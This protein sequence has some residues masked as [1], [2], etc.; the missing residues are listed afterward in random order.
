MVVALAALARSFVCR[1]RTLARRARADGAPLAGSAGSPLGG[2]TDRGRG[3]PVTYLSHAASFHSNER[4]AP[5]NRGIKHL[6]DVSAAIRAEQARSL[7]Y[8][9]NVRFRMVSQVLQ[10]PKECAAIGCF[11]DDEL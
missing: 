8:V 5:S 3:A 1:R 9:R 10:E 2:D 4:I 11:R 6:A 7:D